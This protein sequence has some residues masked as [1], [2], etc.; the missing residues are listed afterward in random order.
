MRTVLVVCEGRVPW[1]DV[2]RLLAKA[3]ARIADCTLAQLEEASDRTNPDLVMLDETAHQAAGRLLRQPQVVVR[4]GGAAGVTMPTHAR[5]AVA[6]VSWPLDERTF[7]EMTARM[8]R[9]TERRTFRTLI[10]IFFPRSGEWLIGRSEDFS[11]TG[12]SFHID[13]TFTPGEPLVV[14]LHLPDDGGAVQFEVE[15]TREAVNPADGGRYHGARFV[16]LEPQVLRKIREF[17]LKER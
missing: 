5:P 9:V 11:L 1:N 16:R 12:L 15:M 8:L 7:L 13:R 14:Y 3:N 2:K 6:W 10:R 17:I 4:S